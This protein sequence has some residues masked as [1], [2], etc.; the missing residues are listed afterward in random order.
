MTYSKIFND[1]IIQF[2]LVCLAASSAF[3]LGAISIIGFGFLPIIDIRELF[4]LPMLFLGFIFLLLKVV[5]NFISST[6]LFMKMLVNV[7]PVHAIVY[8]VLLIIFGFITYFFILEDTFKTHSNSEFVVD[9]E[10]E[11]FRMTLYLLTGALALVGVRQLLPK[12]DLQK[13]KM[14][15]GFTI[16]YINLTLPVVFLTLFFSFGISWVEYLRDKEP[17]LKIVFSES[18]TSDVRAVVIVQASEGFLAYLDHEPSARYIPWHS[19]K[20]IISN[21]DKPK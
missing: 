14:N 6:I 21:N 17:N 3:Q 9:L 10:L 4:Y 20:H 15:L 5:S 16:S 7:P 1:P 12:M 19:V 18:S 8:F 2:F 13:L 11:N